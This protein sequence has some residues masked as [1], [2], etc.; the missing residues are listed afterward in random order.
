MRPRTGEPHAPRL[1]DEPREVRGLLGRAAEPAH[2]G[3]DLQVHGHRPV[4]TG[5]RLGQLAARDREAAAGGGGNFG[6]CREKASHDEDLLRVDESAD[7]RRLLK[8]C[9]REPG[10]SALEG[11]VGRRHGA[12]AVAVRLDDGEQ[13]RPARHV[14]EDVRAVGADRSEVDL[15]PAQAG[16]QSPPWR[17]TFITRGISGSRSPASNPESPSR[18]V[19]RRPAAAW[20]YTPVTAATKGSD[21]WAIRPPMMPERTSPVPPLARAGT[22]CGS[23][24]VLPSGCATTVCAPFNTTTAPH[25]LA[26][27]RA[28]AVRSALIASAVLPV[29]RPSSPG[30][31]VRTRFLPSLPL[32]R[33]ESARAF[34][35]SASMTNGHLACS[36]RSTT[37]RQVELS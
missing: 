26:A 20:T 21:P 22:S 12:V 25:S 36:A 28:A 5:E 2:A 4:G 17:S 8:S 10:R 27:L 37:R 7:L 11:G 16:A 3:V 9:H 14:A 31:G 15:G 30:C 13:L 18:S 6:L 35:P 23:S 19:I 24:L 29:R 32:E 33:C 1:V 34:R